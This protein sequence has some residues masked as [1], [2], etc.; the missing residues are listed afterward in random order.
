MERELT[1]EDRDLLAK[2]ADRILEIRLGAPAIFFLESMRP[3]NFLGSQAL[4]FFNPLMSIFF[5]YQDVERL[6]TVLEKRASV[7]YLADL[8]EEGEK[9]GAAE[10]KRHRIERRRQRG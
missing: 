3:F 1:Q 2:I 7:G 9:R 10:R 4:H 6:A 8:I 5:R